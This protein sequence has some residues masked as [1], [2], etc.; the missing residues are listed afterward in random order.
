MSDVLRFLAMYYMS[1][2]AGHRQQLKRSTFNRNVQSLPSDKHQCCQSSCSE[3]GKLQTCSFRADV[4]G[5]NCLVT[6]LKNSSIPL[7]LACITTSYCSSPDLFTVQPIK[8][9]PACQ[10]MLSIMC[11][12]WKTFTVGILQHMLELLLF[13]A[14]KVERKQ[15]H[16]L[17][18]LKIRHSTMFQNVSLWIQFCPLDSLTCRSKVIAEVWMIA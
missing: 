16:S 10:V 2:C 12:I 1:L 4:H 15:D 8:E 13:R 3:V 6:Y 5:N 9:I 14:V 11:Y 7:Q 17:Y 18:R